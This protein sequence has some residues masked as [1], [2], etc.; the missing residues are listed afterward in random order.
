[1]RQTSDHGTRDSLATQFQAISQ[2]RLTWYALSSA[3]VRRRVVEAHSA[4]LHRS[5]QVSLAQDLDRVQAFSTHAVRKSPANGIRPW[6]SIGCPQ[7]LSPGPRSYPCEGNIGRPNCVS[8]PVCCVSVCDCIQDWIM[9]ARLCPPAET[10]FG[11]LAERVYALPLDLEDWQSCIEHPQ[12]SSMTVGTY[13]LWSSSARP[14][15][16]E[17]CSNAYEIRHFA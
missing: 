9:V 13:H 3:L 16:Y 6:R 11:C 14:G 5:T 17:F 2:L 4:L 8:T 1:M 15:H 7:H 12:W 10:L